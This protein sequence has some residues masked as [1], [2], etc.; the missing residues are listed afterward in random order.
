MPISVTYLD[1]E[2]AETLLPPFPLCVVGYGADRPAGLAEGCPFVRLQIPALARACYEVWS[3]AA[4]VRYETADAFSLA[5]GGG[6]LLA[7]AEAEEGA[8]RPL[9]QV[10]EQAY[11]RLLQLV[12]EAGLHLLRVWNYLPDITGP[13]RT[14]PKKGRFAGMERYR[15]FNVGRHEAFVS[16]RGEVRT[17]PAASALGTSGGPT[18]IFL[19]AGQKPGKAL[20]NPRQVSAYRYPSQYGPRSPTFSRG[21]VAELGGTPLLFISGTAS[22]VGHASVHPEDVEAQTRETLTNLQVVI[23]QAVKSGFQPDLA[24]L[25]LKVYLRDGENLDAVRALVQAEFPDMAAAMYLRAD[26]CRTELLME[27]EAVCPALEQ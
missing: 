19:L 2:E 21:T 11:S 5:R 9:E 26:V 12:D 15:R 13:D 25:K 16:R 27:I 24:G 10:A 1:R 20:E 14:S 4:A 22:I 18:A 3:V 8:H 6:V 17:P 7:L 23:A